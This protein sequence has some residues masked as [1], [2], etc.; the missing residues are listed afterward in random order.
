MQ[1]SYKEFKPEIHDV[2]K[3]L[4][5]KQ[6]YANKIAT[7]EKQIE[8]RAQYTNYRGILMICSSAKKGVPGVTIATVELFDVNPISELTDEEIKL[9]CVP[10]DNLY[11]KKAKYAWYFREPIKM[12]NFPVKGQLGIWNLGYTENI[13]LPSLI[14]DKYFQ[15]P[16][17][18]NQK[19]N[20]WYW[21][22]Y[23]LLILIIIVLVLLYE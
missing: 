7:G 13:L 18:I 16:P 9:T 5:V 8:L 3:A 1:F 20:N 23:F 11:W 14:Q 12:I 17:V 6:P 10:K 4:T 22:L 2:W 21:I 15:Y 19:I